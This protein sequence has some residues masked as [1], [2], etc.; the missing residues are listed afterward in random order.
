VLGLDVGE[1]ETEALWRKFL[2]SL[3]ARGLKGVRLCVSNA[4]EGLKN[5]TAQVLGCPW[6]RCTVDFLRDMLG[7]VNRAQQPLVSGAIRQLFHAAKGTEARE[8]LGQVV[9]QLAHPAPKVAEVLEAAED[10]LLAFYAF[11]AA[12]W[13]Q[14]ALD[15]PAR[16]FQQGGRRAPSGLSRQRPCR[17]ASATP[18]NATDSPLCGAV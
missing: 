13:A 8:P 9:D 11:P 17:R 5:A 4:H 10:D 7:H 12:H 3:C 1:A 18:R 14:A 6:Q 2:R 15:E 16:A